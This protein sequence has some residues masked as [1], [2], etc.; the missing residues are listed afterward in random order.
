MFMT[1]TNATVLDN[2]SFY[3]PTVIKDSE[4]TIVNYN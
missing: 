2:A 1:A 4:T 3:L